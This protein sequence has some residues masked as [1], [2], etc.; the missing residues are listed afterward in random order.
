[1]YLSHY[2]VYTPLE[3]P[4]SLVQKYEEKLK[5]NP[6]QKSATYVTMV[7][8]VDDSI[9]R[10]LDEVGKLGLTDNTIVIFYSD[11]GGTIEATINNAAKGRERFS[12]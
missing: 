7:E 9:G 3:V 5:K 10:L 8:K 6:V 2:A 12:L 1:M 11:N 4:N